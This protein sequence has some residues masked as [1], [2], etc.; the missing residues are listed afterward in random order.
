M[1]D[2][3][4]STL[5][6]PM[7]DKTGC[8]V[9]YIKNREAMCLTERQADHVYSHRKRRHDKYQDNDVQNRPNSR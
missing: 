3:N 1:K 6:L 4:G 7:T 9:N 8:K 5:F 2:K